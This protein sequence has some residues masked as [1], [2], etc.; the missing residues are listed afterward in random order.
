MLEMILGR[1]SL[2]HS[3]SWSANYNG[4]TQ[5]ILMWQK[6]SITQHKGKTQ[7]TV[8]P[9]ILVLIHHRMGGGMD[10]QKIPFV[11]KTDLLLHSFIQASISC[12]Y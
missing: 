8:F 9:L 6:H 10:F 7:I 1:P 3:H 4:G 11:V 12:A 2:H 5:T